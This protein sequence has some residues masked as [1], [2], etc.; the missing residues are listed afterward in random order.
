MTWAS[1]LGVADHRRRP[2]ILPPR[3][4]WVGPIWPSVDRSAPRV[5]VPLRASF[6]RMRDRAGTGRLRP[7]TRHGASATEASGGAVGGARRRRC[8]RRSMTEPP[9]QS[10]RAGA[11]SPRS[12]AAH[13]RG[14]APAATTLVQAPR[15]A[16][17]HVP[18]SPEPSPNRCDARAVPSLAAPGRSASG[19]AGAGGG[20]GPPGAV[21]PRDLAGRGRTAPESPAPQACR[22]TLRDATAG[23]AARPPWT[24]RALEPGA[25]AGAERAPAGG[26][27]RSIADA[28]GCLT[29]P[30]GVGIRRRG[31]PPAPSR[32]GRWRRPRWRTR[33]D[34]VVSTAGDGRPR[35]GAAAEF[36]TG[37]PSSTGSRRPEWERLGSRPYE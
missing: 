11:R 15:A 17:C 29:R 1:A 12:T 24:P 26:G 37:G 7:A 13:V 18:P 36:S 25:A 16:R 4:H 23:S 5:P 35:C 2:Q 3:H 27:R 34:P 14:P 32:A 10:A 30:G 31:R 22:V 19:Q 28:G 9:A 20:R 8:P 33:A 6:G 21:T